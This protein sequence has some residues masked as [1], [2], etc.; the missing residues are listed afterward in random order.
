MEKDI[1][2]YDEKNNNYNAIISN[3]KFSISHIP[4]D[5]ELNYIKRIAEEY[6]NNINKIVEYLLE[7]N[8]FKQFFNCNDITV[9][10]LIEK[11]GIPTIRIINDNEADIT[12]CEH[13]L[14]REH[15]ISFEILGIYEKFA[16]LSIDG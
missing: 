8:G 7:D 3:V 6:K 16:Y 4:T 2:I 12:Y 14:D 10:E 1:F 9:T 5:I 11:I 15:I 13:K